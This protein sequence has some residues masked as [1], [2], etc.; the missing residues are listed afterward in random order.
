MIEH[1]TMQI[2]ACNL[3]PLGVYKPTSPVPHFLFTLNQSL[4]YIA[5]IQSDITN[6]EFV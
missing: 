6:S 1:K 3:H 4:K 5:G 2:Q